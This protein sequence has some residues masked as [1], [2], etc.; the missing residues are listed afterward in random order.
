MFAE[1][2]KVGQNKGTQIAWTLFLVEGNGPR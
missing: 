2:I 1:G